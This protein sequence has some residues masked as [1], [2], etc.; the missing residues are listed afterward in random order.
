MTC[1]SGHFWQ[2]PVGFQP[3]HKPFAINCIVLARAVEQNST[4]LEN[5]MKDAT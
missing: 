5:G 4:A 1:A 3:L 2:E